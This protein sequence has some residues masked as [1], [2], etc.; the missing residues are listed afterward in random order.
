MSYL[1]DLFHLGHSRRTTLLGAALIIALI[2][3]V[4]L[5]YAPKYDNP[6]SALQSNN[7]PIMLLGRKG[8]L[9]ISCS[10][11]RYLITDRSRNVTF[12][13]RIALGTVAEAGSGA[14]EPSPSEYVGLRINAAAVGVDGLYKISVPASV[15]STTL[16]DEQDLSLDLK[17]GSE[18]F[19]ELGFVLDRYTP[20]SVIGTVAHIDWPLSARPSFRRALL[21]ALYGVLVFVIALI[22]LYSMDR[23]YHLMQQQEEARLQM[24]QTNAAENPDQASPAWEL[25]GANLQRYF[26]R[27]LSQVRQVFYVSLGV[28]IA[29]FA[30]VLYGVYQQVTWQSAWQAAWL[31]KFAQTGAQPP[32]ILSKI[33]APTWIASISGLITQF[34]GATFMV[35]YRSTM[36]QAN[37]F[38]TVLDRIN[39]VGIAMKVLDQI[40]DA[41]AGKNASREQLIHLLLSPNPKPPKALSISGERNQQ[42]GHNGDKAAGKRE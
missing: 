35:I 10:C 22:L 33:S 14:S 32:E 19:S 26:T 28:M 39:T 40:P 4:V 38:V 34:I 2:A 7:A 27:N 11:P 21:P 20:N 31:D 8:D 25:A 3:G 42:E 13:I 41:D 6:G 12:H 16:V 37:E 9:T 24:A 36:A 30:F 17:P 15:L 1:S 18:D 23:K 29:G 5:W